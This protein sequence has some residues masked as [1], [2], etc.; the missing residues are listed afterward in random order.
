MFSCKIIV[1]YQIYYE[2]LL[3]DQI[4]VY[5]S[6]DTLLLLSN[7]IFRSLDQVPKLI[8]FV[9]ERILKISVY[10]YWGCNTFKN[11]FDNNAERH[12]V[13]VRFLLFLIKN[14]Y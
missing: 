6:L 1:A 2:T 9:K 13:S 5:K 10:A 11:S 4:F 3:E 12:I 14:K 8:Y 7:D